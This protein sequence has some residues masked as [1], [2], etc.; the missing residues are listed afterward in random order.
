[1][2]AGLYG[3]LERP[4]AGRVYVR[5][6]QLV[7][8]VH[9]PLNVLANLQG[10]T[11]EFYLHIY[12]QITDSD[13]RLFG[14]LNLEQREFFI[15]LQNI[16]G[17][18]A[19][20]ALS[21]L[22]HIEAYELLQI[23]DTKDIKTLTRIPRVGKATAETILFEVNRKKK[24]WQALLGDHDRAT[25]GKASQ[26]EPELG[27]AAQALQ[28]LGYKEKEVEQAF[29]KIQESDAKQIEKWQ[30]ADWIAAALRVL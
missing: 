18:G 8:E 30:A 23:A 13:Q 15:A 22:S 4:G 16:K 27:L 24:K 17:I 26:I 5:A 2:I 29:I 11:E 7:Y 14:F 19:I 28:Q 3:S 10:Q 25:T 1:M 12:H 20:L 21:I 6:G 9:V